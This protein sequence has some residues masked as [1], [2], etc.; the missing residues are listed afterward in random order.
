[1]PRDLTYVLDILIAAQRILTYMEGI[2]RQTFEQDQMR[3]DAIIR[4]IEIIGE[5]TR[6]ISP[7]FRSEHAG[8]SWQEMAGMRSRLIHDYD[9]VS[10]NI[11]WD[12]IQHDIPALI[13]QIAPLI[14]PA[15]SEE[16]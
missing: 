7:Q 1:M 3:Q 15:E 9:E 2:D 10:L 5:A 4:R 11:I 8:I 6:R 16:E 13:E 12:V 14:P